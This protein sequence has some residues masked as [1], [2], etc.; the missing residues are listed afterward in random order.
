MSTTAIKP[1]QLGH[2]KTKGGYFD[3]VDYYC[4]YYNNNNRTTIFDSS[5]H[6]KITGTEFS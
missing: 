6:Q 5:V 2:S 4:Y 3:S 1:R